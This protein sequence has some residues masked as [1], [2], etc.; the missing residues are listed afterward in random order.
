MSP[1][2]LHTRSQFFTLMQRALAVLLT[3]VML[4]LVLPQL[5]TQWHGPAK[6][7]TPGI[8]GQATKPVLSQIKAPQEAFDSSLTP[9]FTARSAA[10]PDDPFARQQWNLLESREHEGSS[11][12]FKSQEYLTG[13][14]NI[15]VAVVDSGVVLQHEDLNFLP[16]YDFIH[17][18]AVGNDGD[19]RDHDPGDPGDWVN[20]EDINQQTVSAG[21]PVA[22]SK[23]HGTAIAGIIGATTDNATGIA[24]GSSAISMLPVRVTGKCGGY[25]SDLIDGIR[26]A[27][28]LP[29]AGVADN[30]HPARVINLSVGF[31]GKCSNA[32]QQA[33][34]DA[35][36]TGAILVTA[37]T[38]SAVN[39][40]E[41]PYSPASC[42]NV[43]TVAATDR[44]GS[45]T[46]YTALGSA[47]FI[48]APGGTAN[49]GIIT[50][51]NDGLE[52]PATSDS[53][54]YHYGSSIAA[55]HVSSAV[56]NLL[57][58]NPELN[59]AG[60][61]ELLSASATP[62][63]TDAQCSSGACGEGRLNALAAMD[64]LSSDYLLT[65]DNIE[66][67]TTP[68]T[69]VQIAAAISSDEDITAEAESVSRLL[70]EVQAGSSDLPGIVLLSLLFFLRTRPIRLLC[71]A[72]ARSAAGKE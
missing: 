15:V 7:A 5:A 19:G 63:D 18:P 16:G 70:E 36:E 20:Q 71:R 1:A 39:L 45:I 34:N 6:L 24:G 52:I 57:S 56:A 14:H 17:N 2:F 33:I 9:P 68:V 3:T 8:S 28:G 10:L 32:M 21:C 41:E 61:R 69:A 12:L 50:T 23:W 22:S 65:E 42:N 27:A 38:N 72:T 25:V 13:S 64:L 49:D 37:A 59:Q 44:S 62:M 51:Q 60:I 35:S 66:P 67:L 47:V 46:P 40:D 31:P 54:G 29:V 58:Y 30:Q 55:A 11:G 48:S 53:Y 43:L 4:L 26:W